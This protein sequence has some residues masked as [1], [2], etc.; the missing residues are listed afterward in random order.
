MAIE[1]GSSPVEGGGAPDAQV[2]PLAL[3]QVLRQALE[4]VRFAKERG[5]VGGQ[6]V[7]EL[8]PLQARGVVVRLLQPA[9]VIAE[10]AVAG[11]AQPARQAAVDHRLLA[12]MQ[13]DAGVVV[14]ELA[15]ALE[16]VRRK[17]ELLFKSGMQSGRAAVAKGGWH[18]KRADADASCRRTG[19]CVPRDMPTLALISLRRRPGGHC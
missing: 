10:R 4:V 16:V 13:V 1:Y 12:G 17:R 18:V 2:A 14:D 19:A 6:A 15:H 5:Q 9:Q 11:L 3:A 7:D 8:L